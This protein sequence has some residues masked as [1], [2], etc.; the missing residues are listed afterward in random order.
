[1]KRV[2]KETNYTEAELHPGHFW[3]VVHGPQIKS[4]KSLKPRRWV[5]ESGEVERAMF[6][7]YIMAILGGNVRRGKYKDSDW[8]KAGVG[9]PWWS[10]G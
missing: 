8:S 7:V 3:S 10:S 1:M 5:E 2:T 4:P 6:P 9:L